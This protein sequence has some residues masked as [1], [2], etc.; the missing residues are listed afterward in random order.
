MINIVLATDDNFVQHCSVAIASVLANNKDV[1]FYIF[2]EGLKPDN[3]KKLKDLAIS[4]GG[5]LTICLMDSDVVSQFPMPSYMSSHIS[6]ATY[7]RLFVVRALPSSLDRVIYMDCDMVVRG[8][9]QPLWDTDLTDKAIGAVYQF[10]AWAKKN[11]SFERLGYDI[12]YGYFNA[13][14]LLINLAYWREHNVTEQLMAFIKDNYSQIHSHDQ[15]VLNAVLHNSV[16]PLSYTWNYLPS[17]FNKEDLTFPEF[18][19]YTEEIPSPIVIHFVYK[20]K[21][22]QRECKH[23]FKDEYFKYLD[24]T[25]FKGWR[26]RFIWKDYLEYTLK[27][28]I[29]R[30]LGRIGIPRYVI[31]YQSTDF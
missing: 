20:P 18:V 30:F 3:E 17:F 16:K 6:I 25:V 8:S 5:V 26:P 27:R 10:N 9:L 19:D 7:Y 31:F 4:M 12:K 24:M 21:P 23:P 2:T 11:Q 29:R 22:W 1:S 14:M 13:G 15:D 28:K